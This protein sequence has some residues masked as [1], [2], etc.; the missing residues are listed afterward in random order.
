MH[1]EVIST[2]CVVNIDRHTVDLLIHFTH[3]P[4]CLHPDNPKLISASVSFSLFILFVFDSTYVKSYSI[5][6]S[7]DI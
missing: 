6:L 5:C 1:Y 2:T 3:P 4:S 7:S